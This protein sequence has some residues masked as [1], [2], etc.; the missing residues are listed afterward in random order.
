MVAGY[1]PKSVIE[2]KRY[3]KMAIQGWN[4]SYS[5]LCRMVPYDV[6]RGIVKDLYTVMA[7]WIVVYVVLDQV[8]HSEIL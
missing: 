6:A 3:S 1:A 2:K 4:F 7:K 8:E 5:A